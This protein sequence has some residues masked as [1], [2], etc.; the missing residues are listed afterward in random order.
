MFF[1]KAIAVVAISLSATAA[2]AGS[3][4]YQTGTNQPWGNTSNDTAMDSAFGAGAWTKY[5][6]FD[7][8]AF[9]GASFVFLDGSDSNSVQLQSFLSANQAAVESFV[10]NGGHIFINDAPN[11][12]TGFNLGFGGVTLNYTGYSSTATVNANGIAAGLTD[13]G[14]TT[15][16]TGNFFSH[17]SISG[18]VTSLIDGESGVILGVEDFGLGLAVFGGQTTT[19]FHSTSGNVLLVNELLYAA[20]GATTAVPEPASIF[21]MGAGLLALGLRARRRNA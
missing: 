7:L 3:I 21:L 6:G 2:M 13:G 19:N 15:T 12:G 11:V 14:I 20:N 5:S 17:A 9:T 1:K 8:S 4:V 10:S 18:P 16:Y